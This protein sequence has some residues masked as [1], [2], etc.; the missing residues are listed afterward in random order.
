VFITWQQW[1]VKDVSK[2]MGVNPRI[3][4]CA[5]SEGS[6]IRIQANAVEDDR[7]E[8][9][10]SLLDTYPNL[11]NRYAADDGNCQVLYLKDAVA[12]ISSF[13]GEPKVIKF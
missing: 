3:E 13:A 7:V 11:K 9:K 8:A 1:K 2:Q 5:M 12:T 10:Q 6:W 4:I